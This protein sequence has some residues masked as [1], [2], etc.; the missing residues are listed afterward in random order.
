MIEYINKLKNKPIPED[1]VYALRKKLEHG[2]P[3]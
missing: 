3:L 2:E 1:G